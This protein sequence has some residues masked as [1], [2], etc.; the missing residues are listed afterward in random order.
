MIKTI[1][2]DDQNYDMIVDHARKAIRKYAPQWTDENAHDPGI[3]LIELFAWLKEMLQFYMDQPTEAIE[4][5]FL[6]LLG[7]DLDEGQ[8]SEVILQSPCKDE[9]YRL[10]MGSKLSNGRFT[11]E[12]TRNITLETSQILDVAVD[13]EGE[14]K[15]V[16]QMIDNG[17]TIYPFGPDATVGSSF[18]LHLSSPLQVRKMLL[19]YIKVF[20]NY[21]VK[22]NPIKNPEEF[23]PFAQISWYGSQDNVNWEPLIISRDDT[24]CMM[25]SGLIGIEVPNDDVWLKATLTASDYDIPPRIIDIYNRVFEVSQ[26][27]TIQS[28]V[29]TYNSTGLPNQV[30]ELPHE[31]L[32]FQSLGIEVFEKGEEGDFQWRKWERVPFLAEANEDEPCFAI[33]HQK[34][35]LCFGDGI[36][37][38]IP[39]KGSGMIR[40]SH[41]ERSYFDQGNILL[42]SLI[43]EHTGHYFRCLTPASGGR[44]RSTLSA[45]KEKLL[46]ELR[47]PKVC[48]TARDYEEILMETPGLM[49]QKAKC[50]PL[51]KPGLLD[52]PNQKSVNTVSVFVIPFGLKAQTNLS[53]SYRKNIESYME[54][55]RLITTEV[56]ILDPVYFNI[57]VTCEISTPFSEDK[58]V[59]EVQKAIQKGTHFDFGD[60]ISKSQIYK[61]LSQCDSVSKIQSIA[62]R[63]SKPIVKNRLGDLEIP[64]NGIGVINQI[65]I[66]FVHD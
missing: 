15:S 1:E 46:E 45:L 54:K 29:P 42:D 8:P 66:L 36:N 33:D 10:P 7:I 6:K 32:I 4:L 3:T 56:L 27:E 16:Y 44:K 65:E 48:V 26:K 19:F 52:Y 47:K 53:Q 38:K 64:V 55:H 39:P 2:L 62:L 59:E 49:L 31:D 25:Q 40:I 22:R 58:A 30:F 13:Y 20:E 28:P 43:D 37:G 51:Y 60:P 12:T 21:Q 18:Y 17:L 9:M 23:I 35:T 57:D 41:M 11:F 14:K 5:Q 24:F 63:C 61:L 50:L 34:N